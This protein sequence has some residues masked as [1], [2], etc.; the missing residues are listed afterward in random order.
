MAEGFVCT[1]TDWQEKQHSRLI[2]TP[3]RF[4]IIKYNWGSRDIS[5]CKNRLIILFLLIQT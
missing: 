5:T 2:K 4:I 1:T 3:S